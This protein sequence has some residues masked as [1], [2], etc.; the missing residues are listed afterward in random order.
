M[1][2][3]KINI[4]FTGL[5]GNDSALNP[6]INSDKTN[7][8]HFPTIKIVAIPLTNT[9]EEKIRDAYRYDYLVFTSANAVKYFLQHY[10][11]DLSNLNCKTKIVAIGKKT[12]DLLL[13]NNI[14]VDLIP[15][16][17]SS[18][19]I[20]ELLTENLVYEKSVL[21]PGS[22][23]SKPD[24]FN[25][26]EEKGAIVDFIAIYDNLIPTNIPNNIRDYVTER[27]IDLFVFT[28][29]S[30]FYNFI[31]IFE[32]NNV[33]NY[34]TD[35]TIAAIGPV[36]EEA[37]VKNNLTVTIKPSEYNLDSLTKEI[38]NYYKLN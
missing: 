25:S 27:K 36:T 34:F 5:N 2:T 37:I 28:S 18:K 32:I 20:D 38:I 19:S 9:E 23:L 33:Q 29:P 15:S 13:S 14:D 6:L 24:L 12:A 10:G 7:F 30:S 11:D 4:L 26:L 22:K 16:N 1:E 35:K 21:I 8:I 3:E 17:S 31:R